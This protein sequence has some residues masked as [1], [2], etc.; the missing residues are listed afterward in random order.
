MAAATIQ[1]EGNIGDM[2]ELRHT[3]TGKPVRTLKV[4]VNVAR[5][6]EDAESGWVTT[7]TTWYEVT[8]WE[9]MAE[10]VSAG[11]FAK[12][13]KVSVAGTLIFEGQRVS[14]KSEALTQEQFDN[15]AWE[16]RRQQRLGSFLPDALKVTARSIGLTESKTSREAKRS[17]GGGRSRGRDSGASEEKYS[18]EEPF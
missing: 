1:F 10:I 8:F 4:A 5:R 13:D 9:E 14:P 18:N 6:D 16:D 3:T 15:M 2:G 17:D 7:N 11:D 12:G